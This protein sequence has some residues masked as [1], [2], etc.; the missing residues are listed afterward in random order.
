MKATRLELRSR[1]QG[2]E[3]GTRARPRHP[4]LIL[5][6][7]VG[8][9]RESTQG[10]RLWSVSRSGSSKAGPFT[11]PRVLEPGYF[12]AFGTARPAGQLSKQSSAAPF[13]EEARKE[14]S[15][16]RASPTVQGQT[17]TFRSRRFSPSPRGVRCAQ[18]CRRVWTHVWGVRGRC[19]CTICIECVRPSLPVRAKSKAAA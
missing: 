1:V 15:T 7:R 10:N 2:A 11:R 9:G 8:R 3:G 19:S 13:G 4:V 6:E 14:G 5:A 16:C 17:E 18:P 12:H